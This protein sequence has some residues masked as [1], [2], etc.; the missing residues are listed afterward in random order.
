MTTAGPARRRRTSAGC[1]PPRSCLVGEVPLGVGDRE[2]D[3]GDDRADFAERLG[4]RF[5]GLERDAA[6]EAILRGREPRCAARKQSM[7]SGSGV[8]RPCAAAAAAAATDA[9]AT[10]P[11]VHFRK[12]DREIAGTAVLPGIQRH[13]LLARL[14]TC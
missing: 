1:G 12:R 13:K 4:D 8:L 3:F 5:A 9:A 6:R 11:G 7:R 14:R 2:V 10:S